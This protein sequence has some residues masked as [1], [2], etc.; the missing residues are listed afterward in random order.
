MYRWRY[1]RR[2]G[3]GRPMKPRVISF[4]PEQ[5]S[6]APLDSNGM[7]ILEREPIYMNLD[8]YEAFRLSY[9]E[10]LKQEEACKK[11]GISRGTF[12]RCLES[13]RKKIA[14]M[15]TENRPLIIVL[16]Y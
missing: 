16:N 1:G 11:M 10:G 4:K 13:A 14:S 15:L 3:P 2:I 6:F 5:I 9:Y 7:P 12:W 8:E